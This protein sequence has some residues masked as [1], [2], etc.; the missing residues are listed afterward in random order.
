[1]SDNLI[2]SW[3]IHFTSWDCA[4]NRSWSDSLDICQKNKPTM[5][6]GY[7]PRFGFFIYSTLCHSKHV[8]CYYLLSWCSLPL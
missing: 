1:M 7:F 8:C 4:S 2:L 3:S 6:K 5:A